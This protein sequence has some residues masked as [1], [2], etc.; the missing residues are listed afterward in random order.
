[1]RILFEFAGGPLDGKTAE[2]DEGDNEEA[3]RYY[4]LTNHGRIGQR[5]KVASDYAIERLAEERLQDD[6]PHHFQKHVY[7]VRD[8]ADAE[9]EVLIRA[10]YVPPQRRQKSNG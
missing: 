4:V 2:G 10:E 3:D 8:R 6:T 9:D 7:E 5:F 1:M